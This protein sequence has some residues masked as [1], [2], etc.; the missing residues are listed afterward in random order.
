MVTEHGRDSNPMLVYCQSEANVTNFGEFQDPPILPRPQRSEV[1]R[2]R[3]LG[4]D[5]AG[6]QV[7]LALTK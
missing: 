4:P 1:D 2:A 5:S 3:F 6:A 7:E